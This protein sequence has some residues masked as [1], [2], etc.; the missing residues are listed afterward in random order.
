MDSLTAILVFFLAHWYLSIFCQTFF[1]HRY[2]AH[3]MFSMSKFWEK[4]FFIFTFISQGSSYLSPWGYGIMHRLHHAYA[5][6][7]Q[8]PHSPKYSDNLFTMMWST[9]KIYGEIADRADNIDPKYKYNVPDWFAFDE[10]ASNYLVR[11]FWGAFYVIFY[12]IFVPEGMWYL[13][14]L[15]PIHFMMGPV[16][17]VIVNWFA[18]KFGYTNF[19]VEDTSKNFLPVDFL[20][21]GECYHNNHHKHGNRANFGGVRWHEFDPTWWIIKGLNAVGIIKINAQPTI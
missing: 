14:L 21:M 3:A 11:I 18:H 2:A 10:F 17:G 5:D 1:L 8:D 13:Y 15:L 6:T 20:L 16:H 7:E 9:K 12:F 19:T 4:F